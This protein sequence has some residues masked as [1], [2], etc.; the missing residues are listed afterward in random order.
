MTKTR[1]NDRLQRPLVCEETEVSGTQRHLGI[2]ETINKKR[3]KVATEEWWG[4]T[5]GRDEHGMARRNRRQVC[6]SLMVEQAQEQVDCIQGVPLKTRLG[7]SAKSLTPPTNPPNNK[8]NPNNKGIIE[9]YIKK[10]SMQN[11]AE[12]SRH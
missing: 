1:G 4:L 9:R 12:I 10:I 6:A 7:P 11:A 2:T 3:G 8:N 5:F